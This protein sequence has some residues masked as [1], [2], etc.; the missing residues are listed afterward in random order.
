MQVRLLPHEGSNRDTTGGKCSGRPLI[1]STGPS[2]GTMS[3]ED[4]NSGKFFLIDSGA[5]ECVF[6]AAGADLALPRSTDLVAANG[7]SI[8][9]FGKRSI[10][11]SLSLIHI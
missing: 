3:I 4:K 2:T 10:S 11:I 6:P 9:T 7:S 8:K 1:A 5:D